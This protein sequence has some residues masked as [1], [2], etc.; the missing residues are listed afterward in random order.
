MIFN[1]VLGFL[2]TLVDNVLQVQQS[3]GLGAAVASPPDFLVSRGRNVHTF[4]ALLGAANEFAT[5]RTG[6]LAIF[7]SDL[8]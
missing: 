3:R 4:G 6:R 7:E 1:K 8:A 2:A 5:K